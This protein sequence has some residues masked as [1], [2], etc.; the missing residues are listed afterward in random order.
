MFKATEESATIRLSLG[1]MAA[2]TS[3]L[4]LRMG[5]QFGVWL[6]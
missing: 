5:Y 2:A 6:R 3:V 1:V 4:L